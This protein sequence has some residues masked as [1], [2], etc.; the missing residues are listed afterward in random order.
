[1]SNDFE[2]NATVRTD[3]GKG[4]S[5]RL[6]RLADLV[7]AIIYGES[8]EP[9]CINIPHKDI[10]K[11]VSNEAFFSHIIT[12][13]VGKKKEQVVIKALQRHPAKPRI[14]HA[15]FQRVSADHAI[16]VAVPLHFIN[17]EK[18]KGVKLGGGS[19]IKAMNELNI[20]CLPK[21]LP[22]FIEVDMADVG[23]GEAIHISQIKLPKGVTS[24]DLTHGHD[25]DNSVVS[26]LAPRGGAATEGE[27]EASA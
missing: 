1:M 5:R 3:L 6:R 9:V 18:C 10:L 23:V 21:D 2:L 24:V 16:T 13:V 26:V 27:G 25:A 12:L 15:D 11:A 20:S 8:K 14:M 7:P 22:E 4:A 17:E 19:I